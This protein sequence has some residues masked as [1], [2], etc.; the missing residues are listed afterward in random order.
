MKKIG[1]KLLE[2][3]SER[4]SGQLIPASDDA[5]IDIP[6]CSGDPA[7]FVAEKEVDC[8]ADIGRLAD[9]AD[10]VEAIEALEGFMDLSRLNE[11]S[12]DGRF[13]DGG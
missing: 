3:S 10:R 5:T 7:R 13:H 4:F 11:G 6:D 9:A 8:R 1:R 12:V 2:L